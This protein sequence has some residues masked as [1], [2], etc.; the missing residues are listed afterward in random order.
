VTIAWHVLTTGEPY[1]Y[2]IPRTTQTKLARLRVA[3]TRSRR[4]GGSPKGAPRS[5]RY[6]TGQGLRT[7]PSLDLLYA[8]EGIPP[9]QSA[10]PGE[11]RHPERLLKG[12]KGDALHDRA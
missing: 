10:A 7:I 6:G 9:L 1:R 3:A 4:R 2:A 12:K 8:S 11:I 5:G